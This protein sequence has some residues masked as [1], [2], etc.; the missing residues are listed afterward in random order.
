VSRL[1]AIDALGRGIA[2]VRGN[3]QVVAVSAIGTVA[4]A[5]VVVLS[6]L[7]WLAA[8]GIDP[9]WFLGSG[10]DPTDLDQLLDLAAAPWQIFQRLGAGLLALTIGLTVASFVFAWCYGGILGVLAAGDAQAP[11]GPGR[12]AAVFRTWSP[13]FFAGEA[14]RLTMPVLWYFCLF[15]G[16]VLAAVLVLGAV[17]VV[18]ALVAARSGAAAGFAVGC[19]GLLPAGFVLVATTIAMSFGQAELAR[20]PASA[21]RATRAA[22]SILGRRFGAGLALFA[23]MVGA[24]VAFGAATATVSFFAVLAVGGSAVATAVIEAV[25]TS[26]QIVVGSALRLVFVAAYVALS[27]AEAA[28][29]PDPAA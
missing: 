11:A 14:R 25:V 20:D 16:I 2:N 12:E 19:G 28:P 1:S 15:L 4:S 22:F 18:A 23:L 3:W 17:V 8:I 29:E 5:A 24:S 9:A 6:L 7:P 10:P 13:R 21:R 26:V 27:R